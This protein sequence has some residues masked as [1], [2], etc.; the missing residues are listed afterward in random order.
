MISTKTAIISVAADPGSSQIPRAKPG[1]SSG[2]NV[3]N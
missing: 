1:G 3:K 2:R